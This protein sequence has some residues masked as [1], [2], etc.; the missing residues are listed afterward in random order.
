[1]KELT[2]YGAIFWPRPKIVNPDAEVFGADAN[3]VVPATGI[4]GGLASRVDNS[5]PGGV[6]TPPAGVEEGRLLGVVGFE[7]DDV[8]KEEVRDYIYPERINPLTTLPGFPRFNDGVWTLKSSGNFPTIA[9]RRG[10]IYIQ[11]RVA[12][13]IQFARHRNN[14]AALRGEVTRTVE[15]FLIDQMRLGAFRTT[16][17]ATAFFV[18]FSEALN[19][20][21][22][23]FAN[24]L[25][26]RIG[27]ATQRPTEW[28]IIEYSQDTRAIEEEL[29]G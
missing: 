22:V 28:I 19:T 6:Y 9:E 7:D 10:V 3:I 1:M 8:L 18:D 12:A 17:P 27:L 11:D 15:A 20:P 5:R 2:E 23:I 16:D 26:G 14:D 29:A 13:G 24:K 4:M 25:K 21:A